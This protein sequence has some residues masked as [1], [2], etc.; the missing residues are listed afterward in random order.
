MRIAATHSRA[1][2]TNSVGTAHR[3]AEDFTKESRI[4]KT[5]TIA[6]VIHR[7]IAAPFQ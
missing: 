4:P 2:P 1:K 3:G 7:E 6:A 5:A